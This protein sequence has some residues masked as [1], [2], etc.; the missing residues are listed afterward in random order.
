VRPPRQLPLDLPAL[1]ALG[2]E[3]FL[4]SPSN[5]SAYAFIESW[6]DWTDRRALI[7]G[8]PGA[9]KTHLAAI[10]A[11]TSGALR[12]AASQICAAEP[13]ALLSRNAL[14]VE[15]VDRDRV[16][17]AALFHLLNLARETDSFLLLTARRPPME[18]GIAMPDLL[19]RLRALNAVRIRPPDEALLQALLVKLF[20]DRQ[21]VVDTSVVTYLARRLERSFEAVRATVEALDRE[22]L[23]RSRRITRAMAS[24]VLIDVAERDASDT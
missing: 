5:E 11:Q 13:P 20:V 17:E 16:N 10:F 19:S 1:A 8:P 14:A 9:G 23:S 7:L 3:D 6:P 2:R 4:V 18:W 21:L 24:D 22:A 15:D 12:I